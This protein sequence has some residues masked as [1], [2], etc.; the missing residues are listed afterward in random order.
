MKRSFDAMSDKE[1]DRYLDKA[2]GA[3]SVCVA[4]IFVCLIAGVWVDGRWFPTALV[5]A[6][7]GAVFFGCGVTAEVKKS[8]REDEQ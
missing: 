4:A 6:V 8:E 1:L 3:A 2:Y 5:V 7:L